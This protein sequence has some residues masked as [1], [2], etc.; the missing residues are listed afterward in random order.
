MPSMTR[1]PGRLKYDDP[2]T[3][4]TWP[5]RTAGRSAYQA[6]RGARAHSSTVSA[7]WNPQG[8]RMSISGS[9]SATASQVVSRDRSPSAPS[10]SQPPARRTCSGTQWP[11][12][13]GGSSHS[14]LD[15][16]DRRAAALASRGDGLLDGAQALAQ[17]FDQVERLVL[18][19]GHGADRRDRV[20][21]ALDRGRLQ[22]DHRDVGVDRAGHLVD[23]AIAHR[24]DAAQLLGQ[25]EVRLGGRER[26]L[27]ERVQRGPAMH[28]VGDQPV[29][30]ARRDVAQVVDAAG[31]D[32]L[33]D[34]LE[35]PVALVGDAD[36]LVAEADGADDLGRRRKER[37][38]AHTVRGPGTLD[39]GPALAPRGLRPSSASHQPEGLASSTAARAAALSV[40][41]V[42][43][44]AM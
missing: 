13:N 14:R 30:V 15:D 18:G 24:A 20:E 21:D 31:H 8:M 25:D 23:L 1:G 2:S 41:Q 32:G 6:G 36:Q 43:S 19:L 10:T 28:R 33:A 9:T 34:D 5:R 42:A 26:L 44:M 3:A 22:R 16:P 37:D 35:R 12:A 40:Y 4:K 11:A 17:Q 29:D 38:D 39:G 27:V 7:R